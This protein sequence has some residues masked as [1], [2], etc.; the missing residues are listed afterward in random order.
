MAKP[1]A[2][3]DKAEKGKEAPK[4]A[5]KPADPTPEEDAADDAEPQDDETEDSKVCHCARPLTISPGSPARLELASMKCP[6]S[7]RAHLTCCTGAETGYQ[8]QSRCS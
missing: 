8:C 3:A 4:E 6:V 2:K 7:G 5:E 1:K